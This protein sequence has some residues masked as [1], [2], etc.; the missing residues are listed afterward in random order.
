MKSIFGK[1]EKQ[2]TTINRKKDVIRIVKSEMERLSDTLEDFR[3][4]KKLPYYK[5]HPQLE[6]VN[7]KSYFGRYWR[8]RNKIQISLTNALEMYEHNNEE[9]AESLIRNVVRHEYA[10]HLDYCMRGKSNHDDHFYTLSLMIGGDGERCGTTKGDIREIR[11]EVRSRYMLGNI[12]QWKHKGKEYSGKII[13]F[14]DK[15]VTVSQIKPHK[16]SNWRLSY[17]VLY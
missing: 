12:V 10:H 13:R 17:D 15:S 7:H 4:R 6:F 9:K 14:N 1:V 16:G 5:N 8:R 3:K 11:R 2:S